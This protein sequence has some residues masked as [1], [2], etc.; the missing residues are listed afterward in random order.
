MWLLKKYSRLV[1]ASGP[2]VAL[3][4]KRE[5]AILE[6]RAFLGPTSSIK[7]RETAPQR[8]LVPL[9]PIEDPYLAILS[10]FV[11][12]PFSHE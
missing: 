10:V 11:R 3:A 2:A 1:M 4:L 6:W 9:G 12:T 7:A 5:N 8:Y